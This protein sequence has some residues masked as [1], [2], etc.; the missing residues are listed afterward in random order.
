MNILRFSRFPAFKTLKPFNSLSRHQVSFFSTLSPAG[1]VGSSI[2]SAVSARG[3]LY[4]SLFLIASINIVGVVI[5]TN[6][7][8]EI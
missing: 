6:F 7:S 4:K 2:G 5:L 3:G 1:F 8:D